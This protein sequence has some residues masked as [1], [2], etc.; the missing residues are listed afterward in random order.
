MSTRE[1]A[2]HVCAYLR[3]V[4]GQKQYVCAHFRSLPHS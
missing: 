2:V 1:K 3:I 4:R